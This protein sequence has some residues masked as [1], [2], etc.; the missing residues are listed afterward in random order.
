MKSVFILEDII[1]VRAWLTRVV[2]DAFPG[3]LTSEAGTIAQAKQTLA[4]HSFDLALIDIGLPDGNGIDLI[5]A[6]RHVNPN[7]CCVISTVFD[8]E[9]KIWHALRAGA[10]GYLLKDQS[11]ERLRESLI[12]ILSGEPPLSPRVAL[13]ILGHFRQPVASDEDKPKLTDREKEIL[14]L[15]AKGLNRAEVAAAFGIG[16]RTVA[17]HIGAIYRKLD[18][19]SRSEATV[20]AIRMG[21]VRA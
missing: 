15:I 12:R 11:K 19:A 5:P 13:R 18:I 6:L 17:T 4:S 9:K 14:T 3:V 8:D 16:T 10:Y 1:D 21:L 2:S 7:I 20:E